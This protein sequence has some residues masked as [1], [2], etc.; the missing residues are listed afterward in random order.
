MKIRKRLRVSYILMLLVPM[1]L[2]MLTGAMFRDQYENGSDWIEFP[3]GFLSELYSIIAADPDSLLESGTLEELS[4]L[5]G[6]DGINIAVYQAEQETATFPS[7]SRHSHGR[8]LT[9]SWKFYFSDGTSGQL[10]VFVYDRSMIKGFFPLGGLFFLF[11]VAALILTNGVLSYF[12]AG[13]ILKPLS[14]LKAAAHRIKNEDLDSPIVYEGKDEFAGLCSAFEEMRL[15][16]KSSVLEQVKTEENRK[17]LIASISHDLKTPITT[18]KGYVEGIK[19]GIADSP[20]KIEKYIDTVYAKSIM[21]DELIDSLFLFSKLDLNKVQFNF[22]NVDLSMF[23]SDI[24]DEMRFDYPE[25]EISLDAGSGAEVKADRMHLHRVIS[26]LIDNAVKYRSEKK[27]GV[28]IKLSRAESFAVIELRDNGKG[29]AADEFSHIF[30]HFY[31]ADPA[32][33]TTEEGSGLGLA[34]SKYIIEAHGGS[35]KAEGQ[36]GLGTKIT[37]TLRIAL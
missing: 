23:L 16:L 12:V 30:D 11:V 17:E 10:S 15:R 31:R 6:F 3:K 1:V 26:N 32:R 2:I 29:I 9:S 21:M 7:I 34:I 14:A 35:I 8:H 20:E 24:C 4:R 25:L 28:E 36:P 37:F 22:Q 5:S 27:P 18:I 13:S 19:D 33:T